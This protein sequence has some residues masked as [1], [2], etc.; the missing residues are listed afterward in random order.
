MSGISAFCLIRVSYA[1]YGT[2]GV[3]LDRNIPFC[4]T[5]ERPW[6]ENRRNVSCIPSGT[7]TCER[8]LSPKFGETFKVL[9]VPGRSHILFHKGN[10]SDDT[11]GCIL[12]G[13]YF[14]AL[15]GKPAILASGKAFAE[16]MERTKIDSKL[17]SYFRLEIGGKLWS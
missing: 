4:V 14:D 12:V 15:R 9:N 10:L 17:I 16:F 6:L 5:L 8:T 2:F 3:L 11:H 7:Y 1:K 13:E